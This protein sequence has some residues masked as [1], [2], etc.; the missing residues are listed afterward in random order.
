LTYFEIRN[1][2]VLLHLDYI[3]FLVLNKA[4]P[5]GLAGGGAYASIEPPGYGSAHA[6]NDDCG[7]VNCMGGTWKYCTQSDYQNTLAPITDSHLL[8]LLSL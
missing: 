3:L 5:F 8:L 4:D 6:V 2:L 1:D 7:A